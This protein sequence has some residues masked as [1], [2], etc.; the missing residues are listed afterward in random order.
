MS[1]HAP[2]AAWPPLIVVTLYLISVFTAAAS[3]RSPPPQP[4]CALG[5]R[6]SRPCRMGQPLVLCAASPCFPVRH[7]SQRMRRATQSLP[8]RL[9]AFV[10]A[11]ASMPRH[12]SSYTRLTST[13][14]GHVLPLSRPGSVA[15]RSRARQ[16]SPRPRPPTPMCATGGLLAPQPLG[17][18][19]RC[20]S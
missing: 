6:P 1:A 15:S 14:P 8:G 13:A 18:P 5:S 11:T 3:L 9:P 10:L 20:F 17:W 19:P 4:G 16:T 12:R 7:S 2:N